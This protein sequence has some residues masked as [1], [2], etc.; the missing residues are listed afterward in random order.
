MLV[1]IRGINMLVTN[2]IFCRQIKLVKQKGNSKIKRNTELKNAGFLL[3]LI[4]LDCLF[5]HYYKFK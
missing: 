1:Q 5:V 3:Y 4:A 2:S